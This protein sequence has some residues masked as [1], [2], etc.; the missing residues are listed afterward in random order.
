M[1]YIYLEAAHT[2]AQL[3][4]G[5]AYASLATCSMRGSQTSSSW[6]RRWR[7][8]PKRVAQL[9]FANATLQSLATLDSALF[10]SVRFFAKLVGAK[11]A[12]IRNSN[13]N[14]ERKSIRKKALK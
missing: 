3:L 13:S 12:T 8:C 2:K 1:V 7:H 10:G 5:N 14:K 11:L 6:L 9:T 4:K